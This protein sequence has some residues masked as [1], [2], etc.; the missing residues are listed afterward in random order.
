MAL[1]SHPSGIATTADHSS[2]P[3]RSRWYT[4]SYDGPLLYQ[5][6]ATC[7]PWIP[8]VLRFACA[9]ILADLYRQRMPKEY[10]AAQRNIAHILPTADPT[11]IAQVARSLFRHFAYYFADLLSINRQPLATQQRYLHGIHNFDRVQPLLESRQG[12]VVAT[13]HLGNWELA[14]RLLSPYGKTVHVVMAPEQ[15]AVVQRLLREE[16][17][18]SSLRFV[19]NDDTGGFVQLLMA[20]R[21]GDVVAVQVDRGT[22][23]RSDIPINFFGRLVSLPGG[24]F[25]LARAARVPVFP[26]FCIMRSDRQYEIHVGEAIAVERG[27]E[28]KALQQMAQVLE[29]YI[30][31]APDQWF[32]FYDVWDTPSAAR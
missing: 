1:L 29:Q 4:H 21:R 13:A 20:L 12:F 32:N 26:C 23:H 22:G 10:A 25:V 24:P 18:P 9:S 3:P 30:A 15:H 19:S 17:R 6:V 11:V 8:R 27:G 5:L 31:L 14:G 2:P 28:E 7:A 16:N